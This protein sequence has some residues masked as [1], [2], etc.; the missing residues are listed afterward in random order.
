MPRIDD[1]MQSSGVAFGTSGARGTVAAMTNPVCYAYTR[2]FLQAMQESGVTKPGAT[3]VLAGDLRPSTPRILAAV[4]RAIDDAGY[5]VEYAGRIPSPAVA[6]HAM[7]QG[8]ASIMVTGSHIPDDR[9]GIKFNRPDGEI[10]KDDEARIRAQTVELP[11]PFPDIDESDLPAENPA[12]TTAYIERYTAFFPA[13][14]LEGANIG[15]Y[16]HSGVSR[17]LLVTILEALGA[18]ATPLARSETFIPVDTEAIREEDVR[19]GEQWAHDYGFDAIVSTDGDG[20]RPLIADE[21]GHWLRGD[22]VGILCAR[23]LGIETVVTP[24]SSNSAVE[25]C[26]WFRKVYRTR[27]GS[28]YVIERMN[29]A[30]EEGGTVAGYEANGGFL[31]ASDLCRDGR[32]LKALPT[33]DA[34]LPI[35]SILLAARE[36]GAT[37]GALLTTLPPRYT[38]SDRLKEFPTDKARARIQALAASTAAIEEAF[39]ELCGKVATT[40]TTDGLRI[41]FENGEIIHLR[42]S[43]NAPELRCYNE[44]DSQERARELN[45]ACLEKMAAWR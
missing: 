44:A 30:L 20:D 38:A 15:V 27:I 41:T 18:A 13:G 37:I 19:L 23:Q 31:L 25:L 17:D 39:G 12:A 33:R 26:G 10:L 45:R 29:Q 24:V 32:E 3:V 22:I 7:Q 40:D 9:N 35:L 5:R 8:A 2:A 1:L 16:Q 36:Q 11:D 6:F 34:V 4:A 28:P 21:H 42:P 43:G 14:C